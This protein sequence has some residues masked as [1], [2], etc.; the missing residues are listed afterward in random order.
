MAGAD[1]DATRALLR[2]KA[3]VTAG[4]FAPSGRARPAVRNDINGYRVSGRSSWGSG[5]QNAQWVSGGCVVV[6]EKGEI[7]KDAHGAPINLGAVFR[8]SDIT[9]SMPGGYGSTRHR[10]D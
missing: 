6:D 3:V 7:A 2:E 4:V 5:S 9:I 1:S 10:I 8:S